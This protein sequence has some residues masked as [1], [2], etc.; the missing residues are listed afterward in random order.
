M[1]FRR[2]KKE[3]SWERLRTHLWPRVS[4]KRSARYYVMRTLRLAASPYAVGM[5]V[6]IGVF[7]SCTPFLGLHFVLTFALCWLLGGNMIGGIMG[8]TVGNPVVYAVLWPV[9]YKL[10]QFILR[11]GE[12]GEHVPPQL[13]H[14]LLHQS[15]DR[16]W[17]ILKP[18]TVG[19]CLIGLAAGALVYLLVYQGV[20]VYQ[21]GR[22][23]RFA[24]AR[25]KRIADKHKALGDQPPELQVRT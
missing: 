5:G 3:T 12:G 23:E 8:T 11:G 9:S 16:L 18:M 17:P 14:H 22:R 24:K 15:F 7:V 1:L 4:W 13:E 20:K 19:G 21:A 2:R 10:G 25:E 6:A